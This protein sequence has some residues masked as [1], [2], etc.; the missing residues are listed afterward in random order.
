VDNGEKMRFSLE[1]VRAN[2]RSRDQTYGLES[3]VRLVCD[4]ETLFSPTI[5]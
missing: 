5:S 3:D 1:D 4:R 2:V